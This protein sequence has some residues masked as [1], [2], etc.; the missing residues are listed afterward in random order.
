MDVDVAST[1][2]HAGLSKLLASGQF[3]DMLIT[4]QG[5]E[6]KVH[7]A[8][9][10]SQSAV[11]L[12]AFK[13][14]GFK[15]KESI[16]GVIDLPDDEPA[17]VEA[18]IN[19]LYKFE[20][21]TPTNTAEAM[22]LLTSLFTLADK[23]DV[24]PLKHIIRQK[25]EKLCM[26]KET[27][28]IIAAV[29]AVYSTEGT[30]ELRCV[31]VEWAHK[32]LKAFLNDP[33]FEETMDEFGEFGKDIAKLHSAEPSPDQM[34]G[35]MDLG[36]PTSTLKVSLA[37][38]LTTGEFSD[39]TIKCCGK[40]LN[41]HKV[42][43]CG[44][45]PV[46]YGAF[47]HN[48][49]KESD[50]GVIDLSEDDDPELVETMVRV[51]YHFDYE[52]PSTIEDL[53]DIVLFHTRLFVLADKYD[54]TVLGQLAASKIKL[55]C[56]P[57]KEDVQAGLIHDPKGVLRVLPALKVIYSM[58][59]GGGIKSILLE[60]LLKHHSA[61]LKSPRSATTEVS[62]TKDFDEF[63]ESCGA[64]GRDL[65]KSMSRIINRGSVMNGY[66]RFVCE[67]SHNEIICGAPAPDAVRQKLGRHMIWN[68]SS[69]LRAPTKI[70]GMHTV[71][72][73][74]VVVKYF[75]SSAL[76]VAR[77]S[78]RKVSV[79]S[80]NALAAAT[81]WRKTCSKSLIL[82]SIRLVGPGKTVE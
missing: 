72:A 34:M 69:R 36:D 73:E 27:T 61:L 76:T 44:Q 58:Q 15:E 13:P 53:S 71:V 37:R 11:L 70:A 41:V 12:G 25:F 3:A 75:P 45:S 79:S 39:M 17:T 30:T 35:F 63:M 49:F 78:K 14:G 80:S 50:T 28:H 4:C 59:G 8:I 16:T 55:V 31:V 81:S 26:T 5:R 24:V 47:K 18:M 33:G 82:R 56:D 19:F 60:F 67:C 65:V 9:V 54:Y 57:Q 52:V 6:F 74:T 32:Y 66:L 2:I 42:I 77:T 20:I 7:K 68:A 51:M 22:P 1:G 38:K 62:E 40:T 29:K 21:T 10:C 64:F 48:T 23:Y 46:L 43:V